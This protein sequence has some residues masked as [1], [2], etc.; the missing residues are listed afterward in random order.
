M[1]DQPEIFGPG[2]ELVQTVPDATGHSGEETTPVIAVA[3]TSSDGVGIAQAI[4]EVVEELQSEPEPV[5]N[6]QFPF[7]HPDNIDWSKIDPAGVNMLKDLNARSWIKSVEY[8]SG[9]PAN[10][11]ANEGSALYPPA[12][13][14]NPY[15]DI[16]TLDNA[17]LRGAI[18]DVYFRYQKQ[19]I[20]QSTITRFYL[21]V[22]VYNIAIFQAWV[23][24]LSTMITMA[25]NT[26]LNPVLVRYN[27]LRPGINYTI[28]WDYWTLEERDLIHQVVTDSL[29][30]YPV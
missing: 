23:K 10:R 5:V 20:R 18:P 29:A 2:A 9:H 27:P 24:L 4:E 16:N 19:E 12:N 22:N 7:G 13:G 15:E 14:R 8:C 6:P 28:A 3:V 1:S 17:Y 21:N 25:T 30:N 11:P 26:V